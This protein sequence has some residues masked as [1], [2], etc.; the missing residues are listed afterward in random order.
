M[1]SHSKI[2]VN[3]RE[4]IFRLLAKGFSIRQIAK[5][6]KRH[7]S[8]VSREIR[9][10]EMTRETYSVAEAQV[11]RN[12]KS[13]QVGVK[14]KIRSGS[15]LFHFIKHHLIDLR[16]SPEQISNRLKKETDCS[17]WKISHET[18]YRFIY[19]IEDSS[20][21]Q[22]W[23]KSLRRKK[24][25]RGPCKYIRENIKTISDKVSIHDRPEHIANRQEI[26]H[27]EGDLVVGKDHKSAIG[28]LVERTTR[29]TLII[30][31]K[32]GKTSDEVVRAFERRLKSIPTELRKSLTY[33]NGSEMAL[34]GY[35]KES[36]GMAVYF[37]DPGC[38]GQRGTNENT[39]G[40][41]RDF[42]PKKTDFSKISGEELLHIEKLLNERPRKILDYECPYKVFWKEIG[43]RSATVAFSNSTRCRLNPSILRVVPS[44]AI[45]ALAILPPRLEPVPLAPEPSIPIHPWRC[46][47][48][49]S[50]PS[51]A[52]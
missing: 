12:L 38:P 14:N 11:D 9:R 48:S 19:S 44:A 30:D 35:L 49:A 37:C 2:K 50:I 40:L 25:K 3:E 13:A 15:K 52:G 4:E 47:Y 42:F 33:D 24:R 5:F 34:H 22:L 1:N 41:V 10:K 17:R 26:G 39:N 16:W 28:T 6:I 45:F 46:P 7:H 43:P 18:I 51:A 21:R 8:T 27:W 31:L 29:M 20:E 23:I 32:S 36:L